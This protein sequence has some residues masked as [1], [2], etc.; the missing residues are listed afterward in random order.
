MRRTIK[1]SAVFLLG[2]LLGWT[3]LWLLHSYSY[4]ASRQIGS[5]G[6]FIFVN[7]AVPTTLLIVSIY[8]WWR[9]YSYL[10]WCVLGL[11]SGAIAFELM[12]VYLMMLL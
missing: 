8:S 5:T 7:I 12:V 11:L 1:F 10:K 6:I 4:M 9:G 3:L 2:L